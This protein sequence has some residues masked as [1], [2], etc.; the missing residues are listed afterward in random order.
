MIGNDPPFPN[1]FIS[2]EEFCLDYV[3]K[4]VAIVTVETP[5]ST[6]IKSTRVQRITISEQIAVFGGTLGLFTGMSI[7]SFVEIFC[8]CCKLNA[9]VCAYGEEK[10]CYK[11]KSN[12]VQEKE[13]KEEIP[14]YIRIFVAETI[15]KA[16]SSKLDKNDDCQKGAKLEESLK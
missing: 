9:K 15:K 12:A 10:L 14:N 11:K 6:V 13:L 5:T 3:K 7:L 4:Y 8:F 2:Y 1:N 16:E